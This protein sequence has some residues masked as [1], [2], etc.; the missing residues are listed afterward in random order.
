MLSPQLL[1][2]IKDYRKARDLRGRINDVP[3]VHFTLTS[4]YGVDT[5]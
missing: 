3:D 5:G 4:L 1:M 2:E